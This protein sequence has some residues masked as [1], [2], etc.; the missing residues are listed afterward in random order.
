M[1]KIFGTDGIRGKANTYPMTPE[2]ALR[3]GKAAAIVFRDQNKKE[4]HKVVI[5]KDTRLSGY[6]FETALTAGLCSMGVDVYL[7]GPMPTPAVA[8]LTKSLNADAGIMISASHNPATD[9]GIKLFARDG[10]KLPDSVEHEMEK[11]LLSEHI[12]SDHIQGDLIGKAFRINDAR[13]R[14]IEY[15][16]STIKSMSLKGLKIVVDCANGAAY[17]VAQVIFSELGAEVIAL[18]MQPDG[19]N[20]NLN[21]GAMH[22]EIVATEVKKQKADIGIALDGDADRVIFVDENGNEV[23]GDHILAIGAIDLKQKKKLVKETVVSTVMANLGFEETLAK[24][25][26]KVVK[27]QVGDRYVM[28]VLQKEGYS[29]GGEQSGHIIFSDYSTTGDGIITALQIL[30]I[31]KQQGKK[32]S[33]LASCMKSYP[34]ILVNVKVNEKKEFDKMSKVK[35]SIKDAE[36]ELGKNGRVLVRY[37]GTENLARI[38]IEGKSQKQIEKLADKIS[39]EIRKEIGV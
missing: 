39:N 37:S 15:A 27:T 14:Y 19:L 6:I 17:Q 25:G 16:K 28:D 21:C 9:N 26:I 32:L 5:G 1:K 11:L 29:L 34:Q 23:D 18:N 3:V 7:V 22:P 12:A 10:Y 31:M 36:K 30:R 8:Q 24:Q 20:I 38:M 13:G 2:M 33:E 35:S 4:K